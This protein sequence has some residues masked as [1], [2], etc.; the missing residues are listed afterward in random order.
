MHTKLAQYRGYT[1]A[2]VLIVLMVMIVL[3]GLGIYSFGGMRDT[4]L[5]KQ[6]IE[7]I[8]QDLRLAQQKAMLL[9]KSREKDGYME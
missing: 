6:N 3:G 4:V 7:E 5:V 9:E 8:K 2:E 1:L